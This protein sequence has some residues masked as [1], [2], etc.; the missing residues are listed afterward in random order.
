M[1]IMIGKLIKWGLIIIIAVLAYNYFFGT[2]EEREQSKSIFKQTKEVGVAVVDFV[3]DETEKV[4]D[5]K[6]DDVIDNISGFLEELKTDSNS[7][8]V[9]NI[10]SDLKSAQEDYESNGTEKDSLEQRLNRI[11]DRVE[12]LKKN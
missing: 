6:Y 1:G 7:V 4:K 12:D 11:L 2:E 8:E 9:E 10:R 3:K 5:G